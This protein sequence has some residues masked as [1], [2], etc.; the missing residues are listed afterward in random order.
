MPDD[1]EIGS[2]HDRPSAPPVIGLLELFLLFTQIGLSSFGGGV[3]PWLHR[4]LVER[5]GW[6]TETEFS[7][8]LAIARIVPGVNVVN[9]AILISHRA[10]GVVGASVAVL[11]L[12]LGPSLAVIALAIV[13]DRFARVAFVEAAL[14]GA[15]AAAI[16]LLIAMGLQSA[17][18]LVTTASS[19]GRAT[20]SLGS[21]ALATATFVL[22]GVLRFPTAPTVLCLAAIGTALAYFSVRPSAG[23]ANGG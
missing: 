3:V 14:E 15:A 4:A 6:L 13:F 18:R 16:G 9:L 10:R 20:R 8:A 5:R 7:S 11:G 12:L 22:I 2:V 19:A 17:A 23:S 1:G 21:I